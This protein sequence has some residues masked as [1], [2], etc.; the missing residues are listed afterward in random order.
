MEQH[1]YAFASVDVFRLAIVIGQ[2]PVWDS[3][4]LSYLVDK[5]VPVIH[6]RMRNLVKMVTHHKLNNI[7][8]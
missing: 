3:K 8:N 5:F 4:D 6:S 1:L 7:H 2:H